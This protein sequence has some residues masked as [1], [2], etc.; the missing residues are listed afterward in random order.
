MPRQRPLILCAD[1]FGSVKERGIAAYVRDLRAIAAP[2]ADVV[3]LQ[4]PGWV[5]RR[6]TLVQNLLL[7]L[8][9]QIVVPIHALIRRPDLIVYPYNSASFLLSPMRR[10]VCVIHDLI[11]YRVRTRGSA[12]AFAY[13]ACTAR[14]HARLGRRLVAVSPFT[15][16]TLAALPQFAR[17]PIVTIPN[18]F[19]GLPTPPVGAPPAHPRRITLISG[20]GPNKAFGQ[21][22]GLMAA[23][24]R[25]PRLA[26]IGFDV[27]GFGEAA[28][29]AEEML[30]R[31]RA[32]GL[33]LPPVTVHPLLP[34]PALDRMIGDN[35][36]MWAHSLAE[37][38]GRAVVEGRMAGRPVVMSRLPVFRALR[39]DFTFAYDND[40]TV[41]FVSALHAALAAAAEPHPYPL[42]DRL[43]ADAL[44]GLKELLA[45]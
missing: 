28:V 17:S 19:A 18:S 36:V 20:I 44:A 2:H 30:A 42:L 12:F 34:R 40:D 22:I 27:V 7:V 6:S 31:A 25:D 13:V 16:R 1:F 26:G 10:T 33:A 37:G 24:A 14:W 8:H 5:R 35:A 38:F 9:E 41:G 3:L 43:R 4:A 32:D 39:D 23:A 11:P 15:A 45:R 29:H 21:A